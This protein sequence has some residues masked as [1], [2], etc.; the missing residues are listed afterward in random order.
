VAVNGPQR[1]GSI[2]QQLGVDLSVASRQVAALAAEGYVERTRDPDDG[3]AQI[4]ELT[5]SGR[6]GLRESHA[7]MVSVFAE[8]LTGWA[9]DE[10]AA[11]SGALGRRAPRGH[12]T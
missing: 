9:P 10:I 2:A 6:R 5:E 3:R 4:I 11:L 1:V 12:D 7:R 8:V